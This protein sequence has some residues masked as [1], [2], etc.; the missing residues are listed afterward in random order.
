MPIFFL[1]GAHQDDQQKC[2]I[3]SSFTQQH[4]SVQ[5]VGGA[6]PDPLLR[7]RDAASLPPAH[8]LLHPGGGYR[9]RRAGHLDARGRVDDGDGVA[10]AGSG[11][12]VDLQALVL[13]GGRNEGGRGRVEGEAGS[14]SHGL[15]RRRRLRGVTRQG[16]TFRGAD[17]VHV[18]VG[19]QARAKLHVVLKVKRA[20]SLELGAENVDGSGLGQLLHAANAAELLV[21]ILGDGEPGL[22]AIAAAVVVV[23]GARDGRGRMRVLV[24]LVV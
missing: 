10:G 6:H 1:F 7:E 4:A 22:S 8:A 15:L 13:V 9:R 24:E 18:A 11:W 23:G 19:Q 14:N 16:G 17:G 21:R 20:A 2:R 3:S 12:L 5:M